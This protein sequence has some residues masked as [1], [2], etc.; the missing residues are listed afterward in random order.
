MVYAFAVSLTVYPL[1]KKKTPRGKAAVSK[2][3]KSV[4]VNLKELH[5]IFDQQ[6]ELS[7]LPAK[8]SRQ[9][10]TRSIHALGGGAG[11]I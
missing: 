1:I 4:K 8:H 2:E 6:H 5:T 10:W 9:A 7:G 11:L 3:E